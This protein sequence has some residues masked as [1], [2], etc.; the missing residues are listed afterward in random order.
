MTEPLE[1]RRM[2]PEVE[3]LLLAIQSRDDAITALRA[4]VQMMPDRI[5][6][7]I[8]RANMRTVSDPVF[9]AAAGDALRK[10]ARDQAGNFVLDGIK[11]FARKVGWL[12]LIVGGVYMVG[13]W[14]ALAAAWKS[15]FGAQA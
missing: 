9:W 3:H 10:Q 11:G 15:A 5:G 1:R 4:D 2:H 6:D 8:Q 14:P 7:A 12:L 13:G